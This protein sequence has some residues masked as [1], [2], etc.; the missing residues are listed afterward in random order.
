MGGLNHAKGEADDLEEAILDFVDQHDKYKLRKH[1]ES[2]NINGMDN[3]FDILTTLIR[4]L[5]IDYK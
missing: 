5:Y 1:A 2:G 3:F 4:L